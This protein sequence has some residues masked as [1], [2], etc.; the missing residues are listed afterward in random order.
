MYNPLRESAAR[1]TVNHLLNG[2]PAGHQ[3]VLINNL[4]CLSLIFDL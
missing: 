1:P 2:L 3:S 4:K